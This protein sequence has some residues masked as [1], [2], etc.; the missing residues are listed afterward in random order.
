MDVVRLHVFWLTGVPRQLPQR[1][2]PDVRNGRTKVVGHRSAAAVADVSQML[3]KTNRQGPGSLTTTAEV[4][5][6]TGDG[7][8]QVVALTRKRPL[9][10][11]VTI[12]SSDGG[13][14]AHVG[15]CLAPN[16]KHWFTTS[17]PPSSHC[18]S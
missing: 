8:Y 1:L 17:P 7:I 6:P 10:G 2:N 11:R 4:T 14:S 5:R 13:V 3:R 15:A 16:S 18:H 9:D 12:G